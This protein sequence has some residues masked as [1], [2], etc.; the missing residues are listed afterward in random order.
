MEFGYKK[1]T[2]LSFAE[3]LQKM[4]LELANEGF[5]IITE[6][7]ARKTFQKKLNIDFGNYVILGACHPASAHELLA[8]NKELGLFLPCNVL[9]YEV[10]GK[11]FVSTVLPSALLKM[12]N[13]N[14]L[15]ELAE[16]IESKLK[17]VI[18]KF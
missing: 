9:A 5:G 18:D 11:V 3:A 4:R 14:D 17:N 2:N 8:A 13:E 1:Q 16:E 6:I 7:D 10:E 15:R 12:T